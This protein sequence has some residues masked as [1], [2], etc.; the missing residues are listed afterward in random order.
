M[1]RR[2]IA[3]L[4]GLLSA[5]GLG[6]D[7]SLPSAAALTY[8]YAD[9]GVGNGEIVG[10]DPRSGRTIALVAFPSGGEEVLG[11]LLFDGTLAYYADQGYGA[12]GWATNGAIRSIGLGGGTPS[13]LV[14]GVDVIDG[15]AVDDDSL[16]FSDYFAPPNIDASSAVSFIGKAPRAGA[17]G[18]A[19]GQRA[20]PAGSRR[21]RRR[22][23]LLEQRRRRHHQ[24]GLHCRRRSH[25]GGVGTG[26]RL[27]PRRR[28]LRRLLGQQRAGS[29]GLQSDRRME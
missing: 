9:N 21:G 19:R 2:T 26:R 25:R 1:T 11:K 7:G 18:E 17:T 23:G 29:R 4:G 24:P 13:A 12:T 14:T 20:R 22:M 15:I 6:C 8:I 5:A 28:R 10:A 3:A 16:Y 27:R